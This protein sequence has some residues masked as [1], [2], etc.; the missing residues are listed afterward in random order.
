MVV[1]TVDLQARA[2]RK[3]PGQPIL[4]IRHQADNEI[5]DLKADRVAILLSRAVMGNKAVIRKSIIL[6]AP[7]GQHNAD[8]NVKDLKVVKVATHLNRAV[9]RK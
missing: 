5:A 9:I 1:A 2:T 7:E 4:F 3:L 8:F 6:H